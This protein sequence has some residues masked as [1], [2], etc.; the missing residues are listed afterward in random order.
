MRQQ[1]RFLI[2]VVS[3]VAAGLAGCSGEGE[4]AKPKAGKQVVVTTFPPEFVPGGLAVDGKGTV[5]TSGW[6]GKRFV[7]A[8][9]PKK[10]KP[11]RRP[12]P[13]VTPVDIDERRYG[14]RSVVA[15]PEGTLFWALGEQNRVVR[16]NPD[17]SG[18]CYAG[19]GE[20]GFSGDGGRAI[21]AQLDSVTSLGYDP[22]RK[23]LYVADGDNR[24]VRRI[25]AAGTITTVVEPAGLSGGGLG[26]RIDMTFDARRGRLYVTERSGIAYRTRESDVKLIPRSDD[27]ASEGLAAD[28]TGGDLVTTRIVPLSDA[29]RISDDGTVRAI[30]G[31]QFSF[32]PGGHLISKDRLPKTDRFAEQSAVDGQGDIWIITDDE[33]IVIRPVR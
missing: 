22:Q 4:R 18:D 9:F 14:Y 17:G 8:A 20:P 15:T 29:V 10:G 11:T 13:C 21:S 24:R 6:D 3:V 30:P 25:D 26:N 1:G 23:D 19:T 7:I 12:I 28:P 31:G 32:T 33:L 5:Y 27:L 16:I 2:V